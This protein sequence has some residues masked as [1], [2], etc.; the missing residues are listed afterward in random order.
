LSDLDAVRAQVWTLGVKVAH[1]SGEPDH[2][3]RRRGGASLYVHDPDGNE[4]ELVEHRHAERAPLRLEA[5]RRA[6]PA[7]TFGRAGVSAS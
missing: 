3:F 1:D 7:C 6:R 5:R 2:I 4:I